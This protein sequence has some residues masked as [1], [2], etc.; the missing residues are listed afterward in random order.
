M[1]ET[2]NISWTHSTFNP[3]IGCT[4]VSPGCDNCYAE[5]QDH[6]WGNDSWGKGKLRR[7]TSETN[8]RKPLQWNKEAGKTGAQHYVFCGS[9]C[10]VMDDE[11]PERAR[12][13]LWDLINHTSHLTWQ[14]LTK[15]PQ[16]YSRYLTRTFIHRNVWLGT[17]AENQSMYNVRWPSMS[18][19]K[20]MLGYK[21]FISYEPALG[22]LSFKYNDQHIDY[23]TPDWLIFGGESGAY[24]RPMEQ[25]WA[26]DIMRECKEFGTC[27]FMKQMSARTPEEGAKLIPAHLLTRTFPGEEKGETSKE[28]VDLL[29]RQGT[30]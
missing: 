13:R 1:G 12:E 30:S 3:W 4:K 23:G 2:T 21:V 14:L 6:R 19:L 29:H 26:E 27:F 22:P 18:N 11:A 8:W 10:D 16:R 17:S 25:I 9:L 7:L 15:R 24:R 28:A 20:Y 5:S